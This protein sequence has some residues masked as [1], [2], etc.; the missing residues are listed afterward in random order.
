MSILLG[1]DIGTTKICIIAF[2]VGAGKLV[3][4]RY[5]T[6]D[7][8]IQGDTDASEQNASDIRDHV[9]NLLKEVTGNI[10]DVKRSM[11]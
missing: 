1:I 3:D 6:N 11:R 5:A 10:N 9:F 7:T 2:D 4:V 8:Y